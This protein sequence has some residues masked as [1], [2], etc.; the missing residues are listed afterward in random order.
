VPTPSD[1]SPV[2]TADQRANTVAQL[3][4]GVLS[5]VKTGGAGLTGQG[6]DLKTPVAAAGQNKTLGGS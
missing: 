1:V 5:T 3:K 4:Y 2:Q 6:P